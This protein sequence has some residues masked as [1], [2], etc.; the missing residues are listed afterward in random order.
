MS[1]TLLVRKFYHWLDDL[2]KYAI[3]IVF[4]VMVITGLAQVF[5]RYILNQSLS[6]GEELQKFSHI[7]LIFLTIPVAY[8]NKAHLG[9][10]LV[11]RKMPEHQRYIFDLVIHLLWLSF[12]AVLI[13]I[14]TD[15]VH[16]GALQRSPGLAI[17]MSW[18]YSGIII[19]NAY[20]VL[21][22]LKNLVSHVRSST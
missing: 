17:K 20:L 16:I 22:A 12:G 18:V 10:N 5:N 2:I 21:T 8:R 6:W 9:M 15:L 3:V 13:L 1:A 14:T 11:Y 4:L 7:W 19:G